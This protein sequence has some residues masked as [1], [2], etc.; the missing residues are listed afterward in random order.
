MSFTD[1]IKFAINKKGRGWVFTPRDFVNICSVRT[2]NVILG[3]LALRNEIRNLGWGL[4]DLPVFNKETEQY[5]NPELH[6]VIRAIEIQLGELL[7]FSGEYA[8]LLLGL[9][10]SMPAGITYLSTEK[11]RVVNAAGYKINIRKTSLPAPK[12]KYDKATLAIQ[13]MLHLKKDNVTDKILLKIIKQ[14]DDKEKRKLKKLS[15]ITSQWINKKVG[16]VI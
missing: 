13:A 9:S 10:K 8:C 2:I 7:Q 4:Y 12:D 1:K 16:E 3:R 15:K 14:L 11:S 5:K 6:A